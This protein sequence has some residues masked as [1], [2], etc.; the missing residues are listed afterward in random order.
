MMREPDAAEHDTVTRH[1]R[2][3]RELAMSAAWHGGLA[4]TVDTIDGLRLDVIFHGHWSHGFGPDF[5][6]AMIGFGDGALETG[7]VEI[8]TRSSDWYDHGHHTDSRYN[9]VILHIVSISDTRETRRADGKVVPTAILNVPDTVLLG[10]DQRLPEIWDELGGSVCAE[11]LAYRDPDRIRNAILRLG[12][13]RLNDRVRRFEG[14]LIHQSAS[15]IMLRAVFDAFGYAENRTP[16][17]E[18]AGKLI[19]HGV[20]DRMRTA[21][22]TER[23]VQAA[24][25]VFGLSGFLPMS[26]HDQQ[27]A[28]LDHEQL[29]EIETR[30]RALSPDLGEPAIAA[31]NWT[32]ART[33][34]ANHPAARLIAA[35]TMLDVTVGDPFSVVIEE[36]RSAPDLPR[37]FRSLCTATGR[38]GLGQG[39]AIAIAASVLLPIALAYARH[40]GDADLEDAASRSWA[41]LPSSEWSRPAKRALAQAAGAA[42]VTRLGERGMQGLLHL[43]RALCTPR[44]CYECPIAAEVVRDRQG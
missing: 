1:A 17:I 29:H 19:R 42:P 21:I 36:I 23:F 16:M 33:R 13:V 11:D 43:D 32:R 27:F 35:A 38:P 2:R 37:A 6:D 31:T 30:W 40:A 41:R 8:H 26:P 39:R 18:L 9:A 22:P 14:D 12:D 25:L 44:R 10:I 15:E 20:G 24:A 4:R 28:G 34:P 7:A 5:A 3:P